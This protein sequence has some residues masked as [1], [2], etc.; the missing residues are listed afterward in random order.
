MDLS[1]QLIPA[2]VIIFANLMSGKQGSREWE[3]V[4]AIFGWTACLSLILYVFSIY[5]FPEFSIYLTQ[6]FGFSLIS[7]L[8]RDYEKILKP[9][10]KK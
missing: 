5:L 8:S 3:V 1:M 4:T 9:F 6:L 2:I 10:F 7:A